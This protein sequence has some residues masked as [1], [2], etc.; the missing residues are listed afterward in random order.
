M[1]VNWNAGIGLALAAAVA[2]PVA[3]TAATAAAAEPKEVVQSR[4]WTLN[5][6]GETQVQHL[7]CPSGHAFLLDR[8]YGGPHKGMERVT[9]HGDTT[10]DVTSPALSAE[11]G[12]YGYWHGANFAMSMAST[13]DGGEKVTLILHCTSDKGDGIPVAQGW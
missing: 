7:E 2:A 13:H 3:A 9:V 8:D 10:V 6:P 4:T 12:N 1:R 5:A 11:A